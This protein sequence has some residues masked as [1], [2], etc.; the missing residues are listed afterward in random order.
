M[1][2]F[3]FPA[4]KLLDVLSLEFEHYGYPFSTSFENVWRLACPVSKDGDFPGDWSPQKYKFDDWKWSVYAK[5][6]VFPGFSITL[7]VARDHMHTIYSDGRENYSESLLRPGQWW[8]TA[9][10]SYSL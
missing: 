3:N 10:L 1:V 2:G 9:K 5:K 7:Q 4:F 8:W 6:T